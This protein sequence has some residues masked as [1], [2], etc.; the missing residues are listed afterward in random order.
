MKH[1][2]SIILCTFIAATDVRAQSVDVQIDLSTGK[3]AGEWEVSAGAWVV[4]EGE[5]RQQS[6]REHPAKLFFATPMLTDFE[7]TAEFRIGKTSRSVRSADFLF[8]SADTANY[9]YFHCNS[10]L[11]MIALARSTDESYW[12]QPQRRR[13]VGLTAGKWHKARVEGKGDTFTFHLD[14][15]PVAG[16]E[17]KGH[18]KGCLGVGS[19]SAQVAFRNIH[20]RG[21]AAPDAPPFRRGPTW[22]ARVAAG[23]IEGAPVLS[24]LVEGTIL[25]TWRTGEGQVKQ[26]RSEDQGLNWSPVENA[27]KVFEARDPMSWG[28]DRGTIEVQP[29]IR[30]RRS[31]AGAEE[32]LVSSEPIWPGTDP[33]LVGSTGGEM[34]LFLSDHDRGLHVLR[35]AD[36]G[37]IWQG[38]TIVCHDGCGR[39]GAVQ[40][41]DGSWLAAHARK[42]PPSLVVSR[43]DLRGSQAL[44]VPVG[45][46][47]PE[48]DGEQPPIENGAPI[49]APPIPRVNPRNTEGSIVELRDGRLL[50]AYTRFYGGGSDHAY[51]DISGMVSK[52]GGKTWGRPFLLQRNDGGCNVMSATLL[53]LQSGEILLGYLRKNKSREDCRFYVR[54]SKDEGKTWSPEVCATPEPVEYYVVNNDRVVQLRNGRLLVPAADHADWRR[55]RQAWAVCYLSD[56]NGRTWRRG[57]GHVELPG[58]GC[59]EPGAVELK[60]GRVCMIIRNSL[61]TIHRA[62]SSDGGDTWSEATSTGLASPTAP[63]TIKRIP[64]TGDLLL[65]WNQSKT[66]RRVPLTAAVSRDDGETWAYIRDL[67]PTGRSFAYTS[68]CFVGK[69]AVLSYWTSVPGGLGLKVRRTPIAWFYEQHRVPQD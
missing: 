30:V 4:E 56:D 69:A 31:M 68:I 21:T 52:D 44:P 64:T 16:E 9:L 49:V 42:R 65:V 48:P 1:H 18:P 28:D 38:P 20:I 29:D 43:I 5:L 3:L 33:M 22:H 50:L 17:R 46:P 62:Y 61:R 55:R 45:L 11:D 54:S 10:H 35:S 7:L 67:E 34:L 63:A 15:K 41:A 51:A 66:G 59:Q 19:C 47:L 58:V 8:R 2:W 39:A 26:V 36:F 13:D 32:W 37:A 60:D 24:K 57:R 25:C 6:D 14:G 53:R 12:T 23:A 40:L 27:A